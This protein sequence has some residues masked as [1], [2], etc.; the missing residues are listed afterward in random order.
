MSI[1]ITDEWNTQHVCSELMWWSKPSCT[2]TPLHTHVYTHTDL[3][4]DSARSFSSWSISTKPQSCCSH[5]LIHRLLCACARL[6]S[7]QCH[8]CLW[9]YSQLHIT[10]TYIITPMCVHT[11]QC[12][13]PCKELFFSVCEHQVPILLLAQTQSITL[14]ALAPGFTDSNVTGV[15]DV[16]HNYRWVKHTACV[17][18]ANMVSTHTHRVSLDAWAKCRVRVIHKSSKKCVF[19]LIEILC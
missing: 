11:Q 2:H 8:W 3:L 12:E 14:F 16:I 17:Q 1:T 6:P 15:S 19:R 9:C 13:L 18:R 4:T 5:R 10:C 7:E